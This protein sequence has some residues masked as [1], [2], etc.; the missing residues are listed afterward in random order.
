M[1]ERGPFDSSDKLE[2]ERKVIPFAG[3]DLQRSARPIHLSNVSIKG[4]FLVPSHRIVL[5]F[6]H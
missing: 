5:S 2:I 4:F 3:T 6:R 1:A